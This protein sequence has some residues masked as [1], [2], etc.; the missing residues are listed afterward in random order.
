VIETGRAAARISSVHAP[1]GGAAALAPCARRRRRT[2]AQR[3]CSV[4]SPRTLVEA[5]GVAP[6]SQRGGKV[7][8]SALFQRLQ[9]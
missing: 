5:G 1:C 4:R 8:A 6:R 2:L 9:A 7:R 3:Y